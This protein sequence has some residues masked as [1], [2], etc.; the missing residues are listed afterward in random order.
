MRRLALFLLAL[1]SAPAAFAHLV[2]D[3]RMTIDAPAFAPIGQPLTYRVIASGLSGAPAPSPASMSSIA[4][5]TF[6]A[7]IA[8][9]S[10]CTAWRS[11]SH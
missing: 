11:E 4:A 10:C 5:R 8:R 9:A 2:V 3:V 7:R 1:C 6:T